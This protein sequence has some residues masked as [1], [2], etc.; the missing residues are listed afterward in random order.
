MI[1]KKLSPLNL[2]CF[3]PLP[4]VE[5]C[6]LQKSHK[7]FHQTKALFL[8]SSFFILLRKLIGRNCWKWTVKTFLPWSGN[9]YSQFN[10]FRPSTFHISPI[11]EV[12]TWYGP[13]NA[14][15]CMIVSIGI[16]KFA[17]DCR[18]NKSCHTCK[19]VCNTHCMCNIRRAD[20]VE[21]CFRCWKLE[22]HKCLKTIFQSII[23]NLEKRNFTCVITAK[24]MTATM[25]QPTVK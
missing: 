19:R 10:P 22:S 3:F 21:I 20:I 24:V 6:L 12:L 15:G 2:L 23:C 7:I 16:Q 14:P 11:W 25:L 8:N 1:L 13:N 18:W 9:F 4:M 5:P 17:S